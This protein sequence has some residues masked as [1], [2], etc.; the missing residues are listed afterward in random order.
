MANAVGVLRMAHG[1]QCS[2]VSDFPGEAFAGDSNANK[3]IQRTGILFGI[4]SFPFT[5]SNCRRS[6]II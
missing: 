3:L 6:P 5:A 4:N 1:L 2:P